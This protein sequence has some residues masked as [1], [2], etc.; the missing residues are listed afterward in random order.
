MYA[1]LCSQ[2]LLHVFKSKMKFESRPSPRPGVF[3]L[4]Q[5]TWMTRGIE[6]FR[7]GSDA[8]DLAAYATLVVGLSPAQ[9]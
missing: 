3:D 4:V 2:M 6:C 5:C 1:L 9:P 7:N 8:F